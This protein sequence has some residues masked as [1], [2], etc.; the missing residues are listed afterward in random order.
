VSVML[1]NED[2]A[3]F[4]LTVPISIAPKLINPEMDNKIWGLGDSCSF[5]T[6]SLFPDV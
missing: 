3:V 6:L 4:F 1:V 2:K 5:G